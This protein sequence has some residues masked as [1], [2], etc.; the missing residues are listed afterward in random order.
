M[1]ECKFVSVSEHY[2]RLIDEENDPV[3]DPR[4]LQEFM[5]KSDGQYFIDSLNLAR[6][7]DVLEIGV[8]TGRLAVRVAGNCNRF[9]GID[10]SEK[11]VIRAKS[12]LKDFDNISVVWGD[13][14]EYSFQETYDIIYSSMVFWHIRD[15]A[16]AISKIASLLRKDGRFI[17]SIDKCQPEVTDYV[18]RKVKMFPDDK[19]KILEDIRK[20]NLSVKHIEEI[21]NAFV[22][23]AEKT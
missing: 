3:Y 7:K 22:I 4:P 15:K 9:C 14:L 12:N 23:I 16:K 20:T 21:E 5:N 1:D 6:S 18:S 13:F 10:I 8:G 19:E 2:D 11:T 17:L